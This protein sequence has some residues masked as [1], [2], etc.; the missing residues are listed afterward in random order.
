MK[1]KLLCVL[2][3][4]C[5]AFVCQTAFAVS[6]SREEYRQIV[7]EAIGGASDAN[8]KLCDNLWLGTVEAPG[9]G[10]AYLYTFVDVYEGKT[11]GFL[12]LYGDEA[13]LA[14][15]GELAFSPAAR[16]CCRRETG[17]SVSRAAGRS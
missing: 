14:Y 1:K 3:A 17:P 4:L 16:A 9:L 10:R 15:T 12:Y 2:L 7:F 5:F 13:Y 8:G 11:Q 6:F